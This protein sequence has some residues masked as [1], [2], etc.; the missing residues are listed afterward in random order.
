MKPSKDSSKATA[1][2]VTGT[3]QTRERIIEAAVKV[4][5]GRGYTGATTRAIA[6]EAGVNE[7]TLF[8]HFGNKK[9]LFREMI[10]Y[11]HEYSGLKTL[12]PERLSGDYRQVLTGLGTRILSILIE[13]R[14]IYRLLLSEV[15]QQSEVR[16]AM[17]QI[18]R[19]LRHLLAQYFRIQMKQGKLRKLNPEVMAQAFMSMFMAFVLYET[20]FAEPPVAD[21]ANEDIVSQFVDIFMEGTLNPG[22]LSF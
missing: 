14:E 6:A 1:N 11:Y 4:F 22:S 18:P 20:I 17:I 12:N 10:D 3:E 15:E 5:G 9:N 7:V 8:R 19:Q 16:D 2:A 21:I 13:R